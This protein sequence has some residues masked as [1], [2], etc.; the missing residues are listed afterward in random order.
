MA[1][2]LLPFSNYDLVNYTFTR[3]SPDDI[4][5]T[6][7]AQLKVRDIVNNLDDKI[8]FTPPAMDLPAFEKI[9]TREYPVF[10]PYPI[11][12]IDTLIIAIPAGMAVKSFP[13]AEISCET[14]SYKVSSILVN[15]NLI[16]IRHVLFR[17]GTTRLE[18]YP[19]FYNWIGSIRA[20]ER[21]NKIILSPTHE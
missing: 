14:G 6:F 2:D 13:A 1:R 12:N 9:Q 21:Q 17:R 16:Y 18:Q 15:Q 19:V 20:F 10:F 8:I 3:N 7:N 5:I 11:W 4:S